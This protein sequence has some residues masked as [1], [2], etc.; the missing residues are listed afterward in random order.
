MTVLIIIYGI[1]A[2]TNSIFSKLCSNA[3]KGTSK[4]TYALYC[5]LHSAIACVFYFISSGAS[6][7]L[8]ATTLLY[9]LALALLI[10]INMLIGMLKLRYASILGAGILI[11]PINIIFT[12]LC[13]V[14]IFSE[15][16]APSTYYKVALM[17][18]SA[19]L[20][21]ADLRVRTKKEGAPTKAEDAKKPR[22][23]LKKFFPLAL[24]G[25][26]FGALQNVIPKLFAMSDAVTDEHSFYLKRASLTAFGIEDFNRGKLL[27]TENFLYHR[28]VN[29]LY[30][31]TLH[32]YFL[33]SF[34]SRKERKILHHVDL[35]TAVR[36]KNGVNKRRISA[37]DDRNLL[38]SEEC[39]V[40]NRTIGN[41]SADKSG[42]TV[43]T[44]VTMV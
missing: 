15:K 42:L 22:T 34:L 23:D 2:F 14:I 36:K 1:T 33:A 10:L 12:S 31:G 26:L 28:G 4:A 32:K 35:L 40:T 25:V 19:L 41:S 6:V 37:A 18:V 5:A 9:A 44:K 8:N 16:I 43:Y 27:A 7:R 17:T 11:S 39:A 30:V 21:Y 38:S 29:Y 13:G 24:A 3:T 20:I